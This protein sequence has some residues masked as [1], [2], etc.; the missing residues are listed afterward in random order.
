MARFSFSWTRLAAVLLAASLAFHVWRA[1]S[2]SITADEAFTANSFVAPSWLEIL[3]ADYDANHHVLHSFLCKLSIS[4][5]G[6]S[7]FSLRLPALFGTALFFWSLWRLLRELAGDTPL[8]PALCLWIVWW[9]EMSEYL[10]LARGYSLALGF[11]TAALV[12]GRQERWR[13]TSLLLGL[14][15]AANLVFVVPAMAFGAALLLR[16]KLWSRFDEL[17]APGA[18][19]ACVILAIPLSR[20]AAS[21]F[22]LGQRTIASSLRGL[23]HVPGP[24]F[25][26]LALILLF[27]LLVLAGAWRERSEL[28]IALGLSLVGLAVLHFGLG[29]P[30]PH[31]RTGLY[32]L[33]LALLLVAALARDARWSAIPIGLCALWFIANVSPLRYREWPFDSDNRQVVRFLQDNYP[34]ARAAAHHPL[35]HML[36]FYQRAW[37]LGTMPPAVEFQPGVTADVYLLRTDEPLPRPT[38]VRVVRR[39]PQSGLEI[40]VP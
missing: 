14:S 28:A 24:E 21:N 34:K 5:F 40:A 29:R 20:A 37:K 25:L 33:L 4:A 17:A 30:W 31:G 35:R 9:P 15:A 7:E 1:A 6:W 39:F 32:V 8:L 38:G 22:Y 13:S 16:R 2:A 3:T 27:P 26:T 11:F 36:A 10:S 18:V 23:L 12:A 19:A